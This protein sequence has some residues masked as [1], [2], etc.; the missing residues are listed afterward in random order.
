LAL[1]GPTN[2]FLMFAGFMVLQLIW[3]LTL[4]PETKQV[5]LEEMQKKLGI[6]K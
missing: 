6:T 4:M 5:P 3:V 1:L 2:I